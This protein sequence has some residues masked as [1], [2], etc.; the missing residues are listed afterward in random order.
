MATIT[1][2]LYAN[3]LCE[4]EGERILQ[5]LSLMVIMPGMHLYFD[6]RLILLHD[7]QRGAKRE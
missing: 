4:R 3:Q 7:N 6:N 5:E 1:R 2:H